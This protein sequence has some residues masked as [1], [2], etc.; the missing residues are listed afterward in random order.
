MRREMRT[1]RNGE[2]ERR[3]GSGAESRKKNE[4]SSVGGKTEE[5]KSDEESRQARQRTGAKR[6][7]EALRPFSAWENGLLL[8]AG[9]TTGTCAA[10]AAKAAALLLFTGERAE[11]V[12]VKTPAGAVLF[13]VPEY[14]PIPEQLPVPEQLSQSGAPSAV[15][16]LRSVCAC[17]VRKDAGDDPDVTNGARVQATLVLLPPS[18]DGNTPEIELLGGEGVGI[19][20]RPGL[21]QPVGEAAINR[22][23][24]KMIREG[25]TEVMREAHAKGRVRVTISVPGGAALAEKTFN[26]RLGIRGGIS[27]LGTEGI[28]RPMS[29]TALIETIRTELRM[30]ALSG[31]PVLAVPGN[32]G[33][34]FLER[35]FSAGHTEPVL[36][37]N[38]VGET[39]DAACEYRA[40]GLLLAGHI[41]KF[42]KLAGGIMNTHSREADCRLELLCAHTLRCGG[43]SA[44]M[45][46]IL[47]ASVTQE[48]V[49][50]LKEAG[51]LR[52]VAASLLSAMEEAVRRR[53]GGRVESGVIF[54]TLEEGVLAQSENA[55]RLLRA[56]GR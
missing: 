7:E 39:I 3:R 54:Y 49:R 36:M 41:G 45:R 46:A 38:F 42:V 37:S 1:A 32:Y 47:D 52:P 31:K 14:L 33:L 40:G 23:P 15:R 27:I 48:A 10:A 4:V 17:A 34:H 20:T 44:L 25:I 11:L 53:S 30:R 13:L 18:S 56:A 12:S 26:P 24:R 2:E 51:L 35:E 9:Y 50:L 29:R 22:I 6:T 21:D 19:V 43:S 16:R 55:A 28:V 5:R 8:R